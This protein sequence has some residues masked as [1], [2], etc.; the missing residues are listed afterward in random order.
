[1]NKKQG[2]IIVA[3]LV[4]IVVAGVLAMRLNG[5]QLYVTENDGGKTTS[6]FNTSDK[7][8]SK[9]DYFGEM[10][11]SRDQ[12]NSLTLQN[13]KNMIDDKNVSEE[14]RKDA[15]SKYKVLAMAI[16]YEHKIEM[17]LQVKGYEDALCSITYD[18]KATVTIK[19]QNQLT[20]K[21]IRE[22]KDVVMKDA[23]IKDVDIQVK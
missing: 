23:G 21:Q 6:S 10:K 7:K 18:N 2:I 9:S 11:L 13:L 22:I 3:L 12:S 17:D 1:M 20:D 19:S 4:L 16:D 15:E 14:S 8:S 5:N